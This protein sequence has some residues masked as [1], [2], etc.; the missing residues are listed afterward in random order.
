MRYDIL[1]FIVGV[2]LISGCTGPAP[3]T[4]VGG[5][6]IG[7]L[8]NQ[9]PIELR[10][11]ASFVVG[12]KLTNNIPKPVN[13][14]LCISDTP[15]NSFGGIQEPDCRH[16]MIAAAEVV[17]DKKYVENQNVYFPSE[18]SSYSYHNLEFGIGSTN[19]NAKLKYDLST[20][21]LAEICLKKDPAE[22]ISGCESNSV[23]FGNDI[24]SDFAPIVIEKIESSIVPEGNQ[25]RVH[26]KITLK[27][28]PLGSVTFNDIENK[29]KMD[30]N[31]AGTATSFTCYPSQEGLIKF[32]ELTK[33]V[34]CDSSVDLG[35]QDFYVDSLI[36]NLDYTYTI[37]AS[38]GAIPL[39]RKSEDTY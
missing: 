21:S 30:I 17:D 32:N 31:L 39:K 13:G 7:F 4:H 36:M 6:D 5:V 33:V 27:K 12:L 9:P 14:E 24:V 26:L 15:A 19:I 23:I 28:E 22:E 11:D 1:I 25:N 10:E 2:L 35:G 29:L 16:F 20:T 34:N 8:L 38:T 18:G 37:S 3:E